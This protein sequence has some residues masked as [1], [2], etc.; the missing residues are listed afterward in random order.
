MTAAS[1]GDEE[2]AVSRETEGSPNVGSAGAPRYQPGMTIDRT[3]PDGAGGVV[4]RV[5]TADE[6][7][8]KVWR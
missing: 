4:L 3:I 5:A 1:H 7:S 2:I 6:L 8:T